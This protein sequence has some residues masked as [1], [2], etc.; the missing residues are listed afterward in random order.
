MPRLGRQSNFTGALDAVVV[1]RGE[2]DRVARWVEQ[3]TVPAY[4]VELDGPWC[5]VVAA[6]PGHAAAP[7]DDAAVMLVAR[8]VPQS[9]RPAAGFFV[10]GDDAVTLVQPRRWRSLPRWF[11]VRRGVGVIRAASPQASLAD[12]LGVGVDPHSETLE[13]VL[14]QRGAEP[15]HVLR[16]IMVA[17]GIPA[18]HLLELHPRAAI[19]A[20]L[21]EPDPKAVRRFDKHTGDERE[22]RAEIEARVE[23]ENTR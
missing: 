13:R 10:H 16:G 4:V 15:V 20:D 5:A 9:M 23:K 21:V 8:S 7:Y 3:G 18:G 22:E 12:L 17:L 1:V 6:G 19:E 14:A 2:A 11:V